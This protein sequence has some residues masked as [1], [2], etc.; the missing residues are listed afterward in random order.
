MPIIDAPEIVKVFVEKWISH[1]GVSLE[2]HTYQE[3]NFESNL[4]LEMYKLLK[5]NMIRT[6][7]LQP[8]S[9]RMVKWFNRTLLQHL[10]KV[11][12]EQKEDWDH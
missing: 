5:I 3:R 8:P 9:G 10:S 6:T 11:A 7:A 1:Y 2:L 12:D 4:F